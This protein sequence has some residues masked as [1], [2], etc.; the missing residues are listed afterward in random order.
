MDG[1]EGI[2]YLVVT[3]SSAGGI[4]AIMSFVAG[5]PANFP[6][7]IIIAQHLAPT[8]ESRL[9]SILA[10]RSPLPV[11]ALGEPQTLERGTIYVAPPDCDVA[12][13]DGA[14]PA[15]AEPRRSPKPSI[16]LLFSSAAEH[17][18]DRAIAIIFSGMGND[19]VAGARAIKEH[20]GAVLIQDPATALHP[21]MPMAIPPT[22]VDV[23]SP[24]ADMGRNLMLL[25][26]DTQFPFEHGDQTVLR[27]LLGQLCDRSGID[28]EQYKAPTI[29]RRLARLMV[30]SGTSTLPE[31]MR[32]LQTHPEGYQRLLAA[33]LIKVTEFFRDAPLFDELRNV[34]L[35]RLIAEARE[36][37]GEL[38]LW[39][40]GTSTGEEAYS[41]AMLCAE[42]LE[43]SD[44]GVSVRIFATDVD[45]EAI[46]FARHGVYSA[47]AL[48]HVPN[49][50]IDKYFVPLGEAYEV[51]KRIRNMTVFGQHDL[52]QRAPFPNIDLCSCRNVL[53]Y[54][55][56]ELQ[57]RALQ[58]FAF[59]L[60]DGGYL[61]LGKAETTNAMSD[62]FRPVNTGLKLYQR[63]GERILIP[64]SRMRD[65][66]EMNGDVRSSLRQAAN[67][68]HAGQFQPRSDTR[69]GSNE[70][71]GALVLSSSLGIVIVD[72]R[73]DIVIIN[74]AARSLL[75][76]HG[77][78]VG[79]DLVHLVRTA[80]SEQLREMIDATL[81]G[82]A[83][84]PIELRLG[85]GDGAA[86]E[87]WVHV[88]SCAD[89]SASSRNELAALLIGDVTAVRLERN[90]LEHALSTTKE[91]ADDLSAQVRDL[92]AREK[93][94]LRANEELTASNAELR[95]SNEQLLISAE[96]SASANEEIETLNEEMQATNEE[97]ETLNE[98]L[99]A[100]VEELNTTNDELEARGAELE[101]VG[102]VRE[103]HLRRVELER[104]VMLGYLQ[105]G[106]AYVALL[107]EDGAVHH[108]DEPIRAWVH[109]APPQWWTAGSARVGARD[110]T[111]TERS[112]S[113]GDRS[114]R[115]VVFA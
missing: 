61:V 7:A 32:Y 115:L 101:R 79:D 54:F 8:H 1:P 93:A 82:E 60:R 29:M 44:A 40:A 37:G 72:R 65:A 63:Q 39:S 69:A 98:E 38:R 24:P 5:L 11:R 70:A 14:S 6:A 47:E 76:I 57:L 2:D 87:R 66:L 81:R 30:A 91:L 110:F 33:F 80:E 16:D 108:A 23:I 15:Y 74:A 104:N 12:V 96:E 34:V 86:S 105:N 22:L 50:W 90:Q 59:S 35:P 95:S 71:V 43:E 99:Q 103:A 68:L 13:M 19:G 112:V 113:V 10:A 48:R 106:Q 46:S 73:Y 67:L 88:F 102:E 28:F 25:L 77:V 55:T 58:L 26:G 53:I 107:G 27:T 56:R 78:G 4:D 100:T 114:Y 20:G 18:G 89:H 83:P 31:Y 94:L 97:L 51:G 9:V 92:T 85:A 3:G 75:G 36:R 41:L 84:A 21:A 49:S 42:A 111:L 52:G 62:Y 17:Y 109:E 45:E 64:P